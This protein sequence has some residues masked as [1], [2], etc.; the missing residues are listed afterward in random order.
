M[1]VSVKHEHLAFTKYN[2]QL[3]RVIYTYNVRVKRLVACVMAGT[4]R[5]KQDN[6][7]FFC[8]TKGGE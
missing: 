3:Q 2:V 4:S 7:S 8:K 5:A 1:L 6:C